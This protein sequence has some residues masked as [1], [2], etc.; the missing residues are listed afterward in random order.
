M[1]RSVGIE[2]AAFLFPGQ[3]HDLQVLYFG[4]K[5][6]QDTCLSW[7]DYDRFTALKV[8][9]GRILGPDSIKQAGKFAGDNLPVI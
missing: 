9:S 7:Q 3:G 6:L 1:D 8:I 5:A 4:K 2:P